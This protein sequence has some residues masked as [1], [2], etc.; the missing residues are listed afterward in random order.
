MGSPRLLCLWLELCLE[1]RSPS[2]RILE[3]SHLRIYVMACI[4]VGPRV[5]AEA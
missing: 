5:K 2:S 3:Q 1:L 4:Q